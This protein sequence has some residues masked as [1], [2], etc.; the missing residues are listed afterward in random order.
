ME[1]YANMFFVFKKKNF[2]FFMQVELQSE[3]IESS[4]LFD[5]ISQDNVFVG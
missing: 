1:R 3:F 5:V 2:I 4:V